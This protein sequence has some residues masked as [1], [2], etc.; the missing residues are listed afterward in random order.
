MPDV[1]ECL[2]TSARPWLIA[3]QPRSDHVV[4]AA[5]H[6][7]SLLTDPVRKY[8]DV[9][10][11]RSQP[12]S[13]PGLNNLILR[14]SGFVFDEL[15]IICD[16]LCVNTDR[17]NAPTFEFTSVDGNFTKNNTNVIAGQGGHHHWGFGRDWP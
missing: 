10:Q 6:D 4:D 2:K 13:P 8:Y 14:I 15:D 1:S 17:F 9:A 3:E 7:I 11:R 12:A 16:A 5:G